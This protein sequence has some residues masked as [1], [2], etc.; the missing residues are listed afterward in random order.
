MNEMA[1]NNPPPPGTA[2]GI[3]AYG[4]HVPW[5]RIRI[6]EISRAWSTDAP[7]ITEKS[8]AGRQEDE[9]SMAIEASLH[10]IGNAGVPGDSIGAL[11]FA[12][13]ES[14]LEGKN[15]STLVS[16]FL[17]LA[18]G[19]L[20]GDVTGSARAGTLALL[21]ARDAILAGRCVR[22]LVV[23]SENRRGAPGTELEAASGAGAAALL[24]S[25]EAP[26]A[27]I[28]ASAA[29]TTEFTDSLHIQGYEVPYDPRFSLTYGYQKHLQGAIEAV[30]G[31][32]R[33]PEGERRSGEAGNGTKTVD[34]VVLQSP[35]GR[36]LQ[37]IAKKY[38]WS[39][40]Q[41]KAGWTVDRL[42]HLGAAHVP[43]GLC[44]VLEQA[45][46]GQRI[47]AA[48]Y[49]EGSDA[50]LLQTTPAVTHRMKTGL[51]PCLEQKK[52]LTYLEYAKRRGLLP[53]L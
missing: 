50:L 8:V 27:T 42:G 30:I 19:A 22:A 29:Y 39:E 16:E 18:P 5:Y 21:A 10:A 14:P 51:K 17:G 31:Q 49:G 15:A 20:K 9:V 38:G 4:V 7:G 3:A 36:Q 44:A 45:A 40:A 1:S 53:R 35:D 25:R 11:Y 12:A 24:L 33:S 28:E 32:R 48:S 46:P 2:V 47:L 26:M 52:H 6:E 13:T 34:H 41:M 37:A 43:L 23:A